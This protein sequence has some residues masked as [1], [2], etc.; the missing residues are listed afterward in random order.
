MKRRPILKLISVAFSF[1]LAAW[2]LAPARSTQPDMPPMI[3]H[4]LP[5]PG[6]EETLKQQI[7]H[8]HRVWRQ[9]AFPAAIGLD[10]AHGSHRSLLKRPH[11]L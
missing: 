5:G 9:W 8:G 7:V 6:H 3:Q 11:I 1:V 4:S 2:P 10:G